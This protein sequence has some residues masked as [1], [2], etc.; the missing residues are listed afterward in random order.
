VQPKADAGALNKPNQLAAAPNPAA[1]SKPYT[2]KQF[3]DA[4]A[5]NAP[6]PPPPPPKSAPPRPKP[7]ARSYDGEGA[8]ALV[9]WG[10]GLVVVFLFLVGSYYAY[11]A[12]FSGPS[13]GK[14]NGKVYLGSELVKAGK[15]SFYPKS[16]NH[17]TCEITAEG[18]YEASGVERGELIITVVHF[19]PDYKDGATLKKAMKDFKEG[20]AAFPK[21]VG[22]MHLLPEVYANSETSP[23]RFTFEKSSDT[24]DIKLDPQ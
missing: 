9:K 19:N 17:T 4:G 7:A 15:V 20:T 21:N 18:A 23:L 5:W 6:P 16:G 8:S 3:D 1:K 13:V 11:S 14:L 22:K 24:H 12:L 10:G 2:P